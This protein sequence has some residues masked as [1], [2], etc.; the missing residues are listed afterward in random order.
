MKNSDFP[1]DVQ[2]MN[3]AMNMARIGNWV[4]DCYEDKKDLI[5]R[6][7]QETDTFMYDLPSQSISKNFKPTLDKFSSEFEQ[8]KKEHITKKNRLFWAERA[9][10][11]ANIL[12]HRARLV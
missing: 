9:L 2:I 10:T 7:I 4:A 3:I 1:L 5:K 12:Q 6:I 11:W 8:L